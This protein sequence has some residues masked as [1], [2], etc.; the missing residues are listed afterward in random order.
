MTGQDALT[1]VVRTLAHY[2]ATR[3][4]GEDEARLF[5]SAC[6]AMTDTL[7]PYVA[8]SFA[9]IFGAPAGDLLNLKDIAAALAEAPEAS[10]S[11]APAAAVPEKA[12]ESQPK[13]PAAE[14]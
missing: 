1:A 13:T 3:T 10:E 5:V 9:S 2:R 11:N 7:C 14:A 6:S 12:I 8:E 4:L